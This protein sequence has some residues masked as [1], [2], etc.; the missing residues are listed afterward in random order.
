MD[1]IPIAV[2]G[3]SVYLY[4]LG[5]RRASLRSV[6]GTRRRSWERLLRSGCFYVGVVAVV[7][8]L[9]PPVDQLAQRFF[10]VHMAQHLLLMMVGA[11][12]IVLGAPWSRSWRP[13]PLG[14]RR[15]V[16]RTV[17]LSRVLR[18]VRA[19]SRWI[20]SPVPAFVL[21]TTDL[22]VWH[23]PQAYDLTLSDP[24]VH[25]A[26]HVTFLVL[27]IVFWSQI[28]DSPPLRSRLAYPGRVAFAVLGGAAN[29]VLA[30]LLAVAP[31]PLYD[32]PG[33][34]SISAL[35]DQ[36]LAGG[37]MWGPGSIPLALYVFYGLYRWL[38]EEEPGRRRHR[39]RPGRRSLEH[40]SP[41]RS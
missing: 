34:G 29:W 10:F 4:A 17:A 25:Y 38:G 28:V 37:M 35:T 31:H 1:P 15:P 8:A 26:E 2:A 24:A 32:Y 5:G 9:E 12:L 21:F 41:S 23:V 14:F 11:P 16:A 30:V 40:A 39:R 22:A 19:A 13:L 36:Q 7:V 18:P 6:S 33:H 27:G 20:A 3:V